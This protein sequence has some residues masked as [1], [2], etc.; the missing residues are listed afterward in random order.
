MSDG[1]FGRDNNE[2]ASAA[3]QSHCEDSAIGWTAPAR[4]L[5]S[6]S[7]VTDSIH[8]D[9]G[10]MDVFQVFLKVYACHEDGDYVGEP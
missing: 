9:V 2:F 6:I 4:K 5:S 1:W 3:I 10:C 8:E 7:G